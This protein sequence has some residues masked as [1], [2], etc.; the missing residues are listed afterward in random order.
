MDWQVG[1]P[2]LEQYASNA[3][4][5]S[6]PC[7]WRAARLAAGTMRLPERTM[8][9]RREDCVFNVF[10]FS[11]AHSA[12]V[13][14]RMCLFF[15]KTRTIRCEEY[16]SFWWI[17]GKHRKTSKMET[18]VRKK[19]WCLPNRLMFLARPDHFSGMNSGSVHRRQCWNFN[20]DALW[21]L[22]G[23]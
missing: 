9:R 17:G 14:A 6:G 11:K 21:F 22:L 16:C 23:C 8:F 1:K 13:L 7:V 10:L 5:I 20:K 18:L 19:T 3:F 12:G 2:E 15:F 4:H